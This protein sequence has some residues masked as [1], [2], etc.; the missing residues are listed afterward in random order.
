VYNVRNDSG[1]DLTGEDGEG[2][3]HGDDVDDEE[4]VQERVALQSHRYAEK[5]AM[6]ALTLSV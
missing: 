2:A 4:D 5:R 6:S 1:R 3:A